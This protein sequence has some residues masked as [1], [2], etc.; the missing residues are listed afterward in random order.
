MAHSPYALRGASGADTRSLQ[1]DRGRLP[2]DPHSD[3]AG[4][5][6]AS[7]FRRCETALRRTER[8]ARRRRRPRAV[9]SA[10]CLS[11]RHFPVVFRRRADP[12]VVA[13]SAHG[14]RNRTVHVSTK[15][16]AL[17][18]RIATGRSA[19]TRRSPRSCA[20]ARRRART[21]RDTW[22]TR[23][24][25][26]RV[27][28]P[29]RAWPRAFGRGVRTATNWS[30]ASTASRS[31]ACFSANRCSAAR[32]NGSKVAL[33]ALCRAL[34]EWGF[35]LLDAQVASPHLAAM[36]AFEMPRD[37]D[38][39]ARASRTPGMAAAGANRLESWRDSLADCSCRSCR[40]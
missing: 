36:G 11:P 12:V 8:P 5:A 33:I 15:I 39:I 24:D 40:A 1:L 29:A 20:R 23:A 17:A 22:I 31:A 10:R 38:F 9:T 28:A 13:R 21:Q 3:P 19:P 34:Q 26:R 4:A 16:A 30:A 37:V 6:C 18:A 27:Y 35:P 2:S 32:T 14:V 25:A 7:R